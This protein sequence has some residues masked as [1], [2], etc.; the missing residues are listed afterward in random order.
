[1][2]FLRRVRQDRN[3]ARVP[4]VLVVE[5][6][7]DVAGSRL[8]RMARTDDLVFS[9][10]ECGKQNQRAGVGKAKAEDMR[11]ELSILMAGGI[12]Q[13]ADTLVTYDKS[14]EKI[15]G[16]LEEQLRNF[17]YHPDDRGGYKLHGKVSAPP[18]VI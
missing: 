9:M 17:Q 6:V 3:Y 14:A 11:H 15:K 5:S 4:I 10:R 7:A 8:A 1:M 12:I 18:F 13:Y 2:T 16:V